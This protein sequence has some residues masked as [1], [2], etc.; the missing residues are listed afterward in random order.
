MPSSS[1]PLNIQ[2]EIRRQISETL[3]QNQ[4]EDHQKNEG[5]HSS[6]RNKILDYLSTSGKVMP[7]YSTL[8]KIIRFI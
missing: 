1:D 6:T 8:L 7:I 2:S 4:I 3:Q 5:S